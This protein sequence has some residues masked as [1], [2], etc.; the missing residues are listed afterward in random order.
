M[1]WIEQSCA[2][3]AATLPFSKQKTISSLR[4]THHHNSWLWLYL[5]PQS[6]KVGDRAFRDEELVLDPSA[7]RGENTFYA[8]ARHTGMERTANCR[9][10]ARPAHEAAR[11][12]YRGA[13]NQKP[14]DMSAKTTTSTSNQDFTEQMLIV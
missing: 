5:L 12:L 4:G 2:N 6:F 10:A 11:A 8:N 13:A 14:A 1:P 7:D 9:M 3:T